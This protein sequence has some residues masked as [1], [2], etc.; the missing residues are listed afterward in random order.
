VPCYVVIF[1]R[2]AR[3]LA[4][5]NGQRKGVVEKGWFEIRIQKVKASH[6]RYRA[7]G[8]ELILVCRLSARRWL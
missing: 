3:S 2:V 6:T 1:T 8:S 7:L 4:E 5:F